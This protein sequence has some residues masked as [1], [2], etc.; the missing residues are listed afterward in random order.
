MRNKELRLEAIF[1]W[2][3]NKDEAFVYKIACIY[4]R[5]FLNMFSGGKSDFDGQTFRRNTIPK[6]SDPRKSNLF[7]YCWKLCRETRGLLKSDEYQP[8][9]FANLTIIKMNKGHV[10]PTCICG[11]KAWARWKLHG[12]WVRE[13]MAERAATAPVPS[14]SSD[15]KVCMQLDKTKKFLFEKCDGNPTFEKIEEFL[16]NGFF[17]LWVA[18]GKVSTY[19]CVLSPFMSQSVDALAETCSFDPT[20]VRQRIT[21]GVENYFKEEFKHE[22]ANSCS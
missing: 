15:N 11:D 21:D 12:R 16:D 4:E 8:Y 1:E 9:I 13:K 2:N 19:Y 14:G 22:Y 18:T 5:E 7:R 3:M 17:K 20:L 6:K 10:E